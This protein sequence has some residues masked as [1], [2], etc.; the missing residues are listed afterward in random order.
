MMSARPSA[1]APDVLHNRTPGGI[2][3]KK[4]C[5]LVAI[6]AG[7]FAFVQAQAECTYPP[8]PAAL[9]DGRSAT[10]AEMVAAM[11]S[12]KQYDT[13]VND[14]LS[15][16]ENETQASIQAAGADAPKEQIAQIKA[17]QSKK[18]NAAVQELESRAAN[19]N[20]QVRAFK[21]RSKS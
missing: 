21:N 17:I 6:A 19:F 5:T 20:E 16:L 14:Y 18:H 11:Q 9:P 8:A 2:D 13:A 15:C 12:V 3:M 4:V 10:E 1:R 7:C